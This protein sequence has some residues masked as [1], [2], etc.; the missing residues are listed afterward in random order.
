MTPNT[1]IRNG[2]TNRLREPLMAS[3]NDFAY[4][5]KVF[6]EKEPEQLPSI[7]STSLKVCELASVSRFKPPTQRHGRMTT[8]TG[9]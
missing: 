3:T 5:I 8:P 7:Y 9:N 1:S 2:S 6:A 4:T